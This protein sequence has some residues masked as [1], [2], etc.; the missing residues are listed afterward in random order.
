MVPAGSYDIEPD[1]NILTIA[2]VTAGDF[3]VSD[4]DD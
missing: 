2:E 3:F 4:I 1:M